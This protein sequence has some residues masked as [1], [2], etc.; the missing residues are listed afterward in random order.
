MS[1]LLDTDFCDTQVAIQVPVF[2]YVASTRQIE[3][4]VALKRLGLDS[5]RRHALALKFSWS[6][7]SPP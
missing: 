3:Q 7:P 6:L 2:P 5:V 1:T 4:G